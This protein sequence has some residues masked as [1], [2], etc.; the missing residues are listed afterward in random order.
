MDIMLNFN[1]K[2]YKLT[3]NHLETIMLH[4]D[5]KSKWK[6]IRLCYEYLENASYKED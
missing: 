3:I 1:A 4:Q 6:V 2:Q 5:Q